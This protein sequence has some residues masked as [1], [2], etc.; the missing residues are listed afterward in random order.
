[1][2]VFLIIAMISIIITNQKEVKN[3]QEFKANN[4]EECQVLCS[5]FLSYSFIQM[6]NLKSR[7]ICWNDIQSISENYLSS[8]LV[9]MSSE[10]KC[11]FDRSKKLSLN[12]QIKNNYKEF[13]KK[14]C[15]ELL[16]DVLESKLIVLSDYLSY[17][18]KCG[19]KA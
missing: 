11:Y 1:M 18:C 19:E 14:E 3:M 12:D 17:V 15:I 10:Y 4:E 13:C 7:C 5:S 9:K 16:C 6:E 2:K 8:E